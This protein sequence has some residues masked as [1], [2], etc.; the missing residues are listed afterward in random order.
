MERRL[1]DLIPTRR[2]VLKWGGVALAGTWVDADDVLA[3]RRLDV[4]QVASDLYMSQTLFPQLSK[5]MQRVALVRSM[6]APELIHFNGQYHTQTGRT[7]NAAIAREI[8]AFGS[9]I[10]H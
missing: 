3:G 7:L 2:E 10:A 6:Q 4:T 8:P 1:S 5:E 9:I